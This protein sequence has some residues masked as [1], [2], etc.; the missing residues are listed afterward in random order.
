[1]LKPGG[2]LAV[3][4]I[5]LKKPLPS[6]LAADITAYI[7][8]LAG[9]IGVEDY[10]KGL[11]EAGFGEMEILDTRADLNAYAKAEPQGEC[12]CSSPTLPVVGPAAGG[13]C[14]APPVAPQDAAF[15]ARMS[16]LAARYDLNEYAASVKI[17]AIV[18]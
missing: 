1:M 3:S 2:R 11:Q 12:C 17:Y 5:V 13:C 8:C 16:G 18:R 7:G 15:H 9:A 10:R 14:S 4:D 6:E